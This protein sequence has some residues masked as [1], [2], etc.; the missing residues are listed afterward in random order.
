M[1]Q[2]EQNEE[3]EIDLLDLAYMLL[4]NWHYL[5]ICLLAG[6][7]LLNAYS[8]FCIQPTY[9][10]TSK[11][12]IVST[13]DESDRYTCIADHCNNDRSAAVDGS[14]RDDGGGG[15]V[16]SAGYHEYEGTEH[17]AACKTSGI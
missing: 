14:C 4:D 8:F 2:K 7:L 12:Y 16:L 9:Q 5:L 15:C 11:L 1:N 13:S 17:C 6:A 10:S 3:M